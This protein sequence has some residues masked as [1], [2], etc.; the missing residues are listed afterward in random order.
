MCV[1]LLPSWPEVVEIVCQYECDVNKWQNLEVGL[2]ET[3]MD[4]QDLD[5]LRSE[6]GGITS[7]ETGYSQ[8]FEERSTFK[9]FLVLN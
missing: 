5:K 3:P 9:V 2:E 6:S 8:K 7:R 1:P 4:K